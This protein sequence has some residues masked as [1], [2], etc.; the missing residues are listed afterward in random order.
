MTVSYSQDFGPFDGKVWLNCAPPLPRVAAAAA[1]QAIA[2]K[3]APHRLTTERFVRA[4]APGAGAPHWRRARR[5]ILASSASYGLPLTANG[6]P[7]RTGD[8]VLLMQGDFP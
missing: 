4:A 7:C 5:I 8:E 1:R 2:W 6:M 3:T